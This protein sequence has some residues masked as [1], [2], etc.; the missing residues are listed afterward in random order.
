[1]SAPVL[2]CRQLST[3]WKQSLAKFFK[4][5][6][7]AGDYL[8]FHPHPL[9]ATEADRKCEYVGNDLYYVFAEGRTVLAYAMLRGWDEGFS[10]PSLGI[11]VHPSVRG[12]GLGRVFMH[13]LHIAARRKG[14]TKVRLKVHQSN[15]YAI[16]LYT[17][18]G[19]EFIDKE[20]DQL[21][22]IKDLLRV[23][24]E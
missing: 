2:E 20:G 4:D 10:V 15:T 11:V 16:R 12:I 5:L 8:Y 1:M 3:E 9:T 21:I 14:A 22:G 24:I 17:S 13:F 23:H 18:L 6:D 19:Y 7:D